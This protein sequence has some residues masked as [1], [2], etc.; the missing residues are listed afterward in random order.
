MWYLMLKKL[1]D[2]QDF[3]CLTT[4]YL[5]TLLKINFIE[6]FLMAS[7]LLVPTASF[8]VSLKMQVRKHYTR[9]IKIITNI[10]YYFRRIEN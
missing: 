6:F 8:P 4:T 5:K 10:S 3:S 9:L 1:T 7:L 2:A